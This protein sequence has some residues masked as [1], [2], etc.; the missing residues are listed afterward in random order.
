MTK[1]EFVQQT[2]EKLLAQGDYAATEL[3]NGGCEYR[4]KD[5]RKCAIGVWIPD[6]L[7]DPKMEGIYIGSEGPT[8]DPIRKFLYQL[9]PDASLGFFAEVQSQLHDSRVRQYP[10]LPLMTIEEA[11][12]WYDAR[13]VDKP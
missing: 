8:F 11:L 5:G 13:S 4:T 2:A 3:N 10:R 7:Y 1:R 12:E 9:V 6:E